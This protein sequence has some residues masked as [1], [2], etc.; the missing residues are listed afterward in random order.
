MSF[1]CTSS[2]FGYQGLDVFRQLGSGGTLL[3]RLLLIVF[4]FWPL[5]IWLPLIP[6]GLQEC[7]QSCGPETGAQG[8]RHNLLLLHVPQEDLADKHLS[9]GWSS[10]LAVSDVD[11]PFRVQAEPWARKQSSGDIASR[12]LNHR[13]ISLAPYFLFF[14]MKVKDEM[15]GE[16]GRSKP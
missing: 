6:A 8:N 2:V 7:R 13:L 9:W 11:K 10:N 16:R 15:R 14:Q 4:L 1:S 5:E 3:P 12:I